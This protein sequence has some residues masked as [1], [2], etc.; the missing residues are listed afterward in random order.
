MKPKPFDRNRFLETE[1]RRIEDQVT[2]F[3]VAGD[4]AGEAAAQASAINDQVVFG[5]L[6]Q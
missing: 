2:G 5:K 6:F 1:I 4:L 3:V